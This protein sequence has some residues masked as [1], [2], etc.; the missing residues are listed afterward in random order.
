MQEFII[1]IVGMAIAFFVIIVIFREYFKL[2][3]KYFEAIEN[4]DKELF[5]SFLSE[6]QLILKSIKKIKKSHKQ[7]EADFKTGLTAR[8]MAAIR[9][10]NELMK[11]LKHAM[12]E[13]E[14]LNSR[15]KVLSR[16]I[17]LDK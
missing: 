16:G 9:R 12:G 13:I 11:A 1:Y 5:D 3:K 6:Q 15:I 17:K 7:M 4:A 14:R 10:S 2:E 8:E